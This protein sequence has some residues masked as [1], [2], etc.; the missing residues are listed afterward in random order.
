[1]PGDAEIVAKY[2]Q[3]LKNRL[4]QCKEYKIILTEAG[5]LK[6]GYRKIPEET[7]ISNLKNPEKLMVVEPQEAKFGGEE[8]YNCYF[9][10]NKHLAHRYI[11]VFKHEEKRILIPSVI[12]IERQWQEEAEKRV[13]RNK[14][15]MQ[16]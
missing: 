15:R 9:G 6:S 11:L 13:I 12:K 7:I 2:V 16:L 1:M 5:R 10:F 14:D 8:K 4:L 3:E